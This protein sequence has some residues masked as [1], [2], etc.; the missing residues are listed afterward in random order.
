MSGN[1]TYFIYVAPGNTTPDYFLKHRT[2]TQ[3]EEEADP[4]QVGRRR[5]MEK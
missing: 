4:W 3:G 1:L 2:S 5:Y